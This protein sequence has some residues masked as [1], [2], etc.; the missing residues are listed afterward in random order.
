VDDVE[1]QRDIVFWVLERLGYSVTSVSSGEE[2]VDYLKDYSADLVILDMIM[3]PG[4]DGLE[5]Y[6]RILDP[7][8]LRR[9]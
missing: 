2:A 7:I 6:K 3:D 4:I 8:L 9:H 1:E 5:A